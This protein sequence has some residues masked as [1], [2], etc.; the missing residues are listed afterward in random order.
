MNEVRLPIETKREGDK[1]TKICVEDSYKFLNRIIEPLNKMYNNVADIT[2]SL[3]QEYGNYEGEFII[4]VG[5]SEPCSG[6]QFNEEIGNE[7]A[8]RKAKLKA[9]LKKYRILDRTFKELDKFYST[10]V[11]EINTIEKYLS[12]DIYAIRQY[13]EDFMK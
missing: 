11:T 4:G 9:N 2:D 8:F 13:N 1:I 7:I 6:D 12:D 5:V 10:L 3:H